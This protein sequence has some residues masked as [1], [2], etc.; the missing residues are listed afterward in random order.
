M[1]FKVIYEE[2]PQDKQIAFDLA[3]QLIAKL[4]EE[5][6]EGEDAENSL[7]CGGFTKVLERSGVWD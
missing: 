1:A 7:L 6:L 4:L 2:V 3:I 5:G